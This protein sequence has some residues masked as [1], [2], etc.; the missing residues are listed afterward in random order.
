MAGNSEGWPMKIEKPKCLWSRVPKDTVLVWRSRVSVSPLFLPALDL[1][2][3]DF[4]FPCKDLISPRYSDSL[5]ELSEFNAQ[6]I[7]RSVGTRLKMSEQFTREPATSHESS[8][9]FSPKQGRVD[10]HSTLKSSG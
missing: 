1:T 8:I 7:P 4:V 3:F 2:L 5:S 10:S 9:E 6:H